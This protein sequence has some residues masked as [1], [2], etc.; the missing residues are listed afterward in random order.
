VCEEVDALPD[1]APEPIDG[2]F[3]CG[4]QQAFQLR[5]GH[6]YRVEV[7]AVWREVKQRCT[8]SFDQ[9]AQARPLV[10]VTSPMV[11]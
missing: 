9:L 8:R 10:A 4:S 3:G 7:R 11:V 2:A 1:T 6:L 5:E